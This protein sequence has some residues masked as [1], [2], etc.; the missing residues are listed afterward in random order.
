MH[1]HKTIYLGRLYFL[2]LGRFKSHNLSCFNTVISTMRIILRAVRVSN[3]DSHNAE[4]LPENPF[5]LRLSEFAYLSGRRVEMRRLA[6][7]CYKQKM[8]LNFIGT[9][10]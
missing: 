6:L 9:F 3:L 8:I 7:F 5:T 2:L 1:L 10:H 4:F